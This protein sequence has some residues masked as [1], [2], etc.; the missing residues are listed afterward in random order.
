L[1]GNA[2]GP[3]LFGYL[4]DRVGFKWVMYIG[5]IIVICYAPIVLYY[6]I[7]RAHENKQIGIVESLRKNTTTQYEQ[8]PDG[9]ENQA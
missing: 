8:L 3:I 5:A 6:G 4:Y 9:E 7:Q 2:I 1:S